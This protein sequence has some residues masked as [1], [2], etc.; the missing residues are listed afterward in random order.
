MNQ[1]SSKATKPEEQEKVWVL[2][3]CSALGAFV[4]GFVDLMNHGDQS[5]T[6]KVAEVIRNYIY[7]PVGRGGIYAL[8]LLV[9][10]GS[11]SCI[12]YSPKSKLDA[13]ARGLAVMTLLNTSA[14]TYTEKGLSGSEGESTDVHSFIQELYAGNQEPAMSS[15]KITLKFEN[16]APEDV[17]V[18]VTLRG[19]RSEKSLGRQR[20]RTKEFTIA[21]PA[22][23]YILQIEA[24]G[25]KRTQISINMVK[26][27]V[28]NYIVTL[29]PSDVP[30][31]IQKLISPDEI[32][33]GK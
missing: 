26:D 20:I 12:I 33:P 25:Y 28:M 1:E 6:M 23:S 7:S 21:R 19:G 5:T 10:L 24:E 29:I 15:C 27:E 9:L 18:M 30:L 14:P 4:V 8:I 3:L 11:G 13:F 2:L 31:N 22:G 17:N 16:G 32:E